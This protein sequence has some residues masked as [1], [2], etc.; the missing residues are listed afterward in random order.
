MGCCCTKEAEIAIPPG[1]QDVTPNDS[2]ANSPATKASNPI[3]AS[4]SKQTTESNPGNNEPSTLTGFPSEPKRSQA[5][6]AAPAGAVPI[7]KGEN[8]PPGWGGTPEVEDEIEVELDERAKG[9][10]A[11]QN[12][13]GGNGYVSGTRKDQEI[14]DGVMDRIKGLEDAGLQTKKKMGLKMLTPRIITDVKEKWDR[15]GNVTRYMTHYIEEPDGRK[16]T[17]KETIY[18]AAGDPDPMAQE[19]VA[20]T[21]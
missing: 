8:P 17:Q 19:P 4:G 18:I 10:R 12:V 1:D 21:E 5:A 20:E 6:P 9:P 13:P 16:H 15:D 7:N 14:S 2:N 11:L 3:P